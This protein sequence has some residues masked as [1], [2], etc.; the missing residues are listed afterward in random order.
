MNGRRERVRLFSAAGP[1][2]KTS[3]ARKRICRGTLMY[4]LRCRPGCRQMERRTTSLE[5]KDN[6]KTELNTCDNLQGKRRL[7]QAYLWREQL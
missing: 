1:V 6:R 4:S 2:P 7:Y 3:A 5:K